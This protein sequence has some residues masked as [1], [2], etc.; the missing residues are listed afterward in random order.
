MSNQRVKQCNVWWGEGQA[1]GARFVPC[2]S[3]EQ[4]FYTFDPLIDGLVPL[5]SLS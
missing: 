3:P 2:P 1:S 5:L 4:G